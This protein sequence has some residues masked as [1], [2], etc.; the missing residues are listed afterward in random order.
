MA[1]KPEWHIEFYTDHRKHTPVLDYLNGLPQKDQAKIRNHL[2]LLHQFGNQLGPPQAKKTQREGTHSLGIAAHAD[3]IFYF[4]HTGRR[5]IL[6]H[7]FAKKKDRTD[8]NEIQIALNR[9]KAFLE[10]KDE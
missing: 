5:I 1:D 9:L 7:A 6:L 4:F 8:E 3:R 2:R 10:R